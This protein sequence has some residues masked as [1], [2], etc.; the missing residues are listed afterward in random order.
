MRFVIKGRGVELTEDIKSYAKE[1]LFFK[2]QEYFD[3]SSCVM[4]VEII[5]E[6]GSKGGV[7]KRVEVTLNLPEKNVIHLSEQ[8]DDIFGSINILEERLEED[9]RRYKEKKIDQSR[10]PRKYKAAEIIEEQEGE[11]DKKLRQD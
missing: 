5:N 1:K 2:A 9:L 8:T 6:R 11:I 4:D 3:D 10:Y 7:D